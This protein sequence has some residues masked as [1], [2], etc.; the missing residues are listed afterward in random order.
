MESSTGTAG[1]LPST[2]IDY[3][4]SHDLDFEQLAALF[5]SAGWGYRANDPAMLRAMVN[6]A[7]YVASAHDPEN[8]DK[9]VGFARAISDGVTNAY[10]GSVAVLPEYRGRRIGTELVRRLMEGHDTV[11]FVLHARK[12]VHPFYRKLGFDDAVDFLVRDRK[13]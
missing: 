13:G 8:G 1:N 7:K 5:R 10:V 6:G 12:E 11:R 4:T 2:L 3:R 9:L